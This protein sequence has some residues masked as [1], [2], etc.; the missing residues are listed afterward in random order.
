MGKVTTI[1]GG[2]VRIQ[3]VRER[4]E[5]GEGNPKKWIGGDVRAVVEIKSG[6]R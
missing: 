4:R 6:T 2:D 1:L 5:E 3:Q